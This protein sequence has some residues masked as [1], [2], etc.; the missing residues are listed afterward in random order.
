MGK[1][2]SIDDLFDSSPLFSE[3]LLKSEVSDS[4]RCAYRE[5]LEGELEVE[6]H[7]WAKE[8]LGTGDFDPAKP[9]SF[10][11]GFELKA[12]RAHAKTTLKT[13]GIGAVVAGISFG[14][15][16]SFLNSF[17]D[18]VFFSFLLGSGAGLVVYIRYVLPSFQGWFSELERLEDGAGFIGGLGVYLALCVAIITAPVWLAKIASE[19][20]NLKYY[21]VLS[22]SIPAYLFIALSIAYLSGRA[23]QKTRKVREAAAALS[24]AEVMK[25]RKRAPRAVLWERVRAR[26]FYILRSF[27]NEQLS[28]VVS[29][30]VSAAQAVIDAA[31]RCKSARAAEVDAIW[32]E[33]GG[34]LSDSGLRDGA[35][36]ELGQIER[37]IDREVERKDELI[38]ASQKLQQ[39]AHDLEARV[40][41][42]FKRI[43]GLKSGTDRYRSIEL[44]MNILRREL[45]EEEVHTEEQH[46]RIKQL[47]FEMKRLV[48]SLFSVV[49]DQHSRQL[50]EREVE[51]LPL[52]AA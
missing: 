34:G 10:I 32:R 13:L 30:K 9:L 21:G 3:E 35:V 16:N 40:R 31:I 52:R 24:H 39:Q 36:H 2:T 1:D 51:A 6:S 33:V 37:Q 50:A 38:A 27:I 17:P 49:S 48:L 42:Q 5:R 12:R 22:L 43:E 4:I 25:V 28:H 41:A 45:G 15:L 44:R 20:W 8:S 47:E 46:L 23:E 11:P 18:S 7:T 14:I 29:A 26:E 19:L